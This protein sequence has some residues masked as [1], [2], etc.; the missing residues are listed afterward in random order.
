MTVKDRFASSICWHVQETFGPVDPA[1]VHT[2]VFDWLHRCFPEAERPR[3][4]ILLADADGTPAPPEPGVPARDWKLVRVEDDALFGARL[5]NWFGSLTDRDSDEILLVVAANCLGVNYSHK[6]GDEATIYPITR[7]LWLELSG[8][9]RDQA[10]PVL[11]AASTVGSAGLLRAAGDLVLTHP[12]PAIASIRRLGHRSSTGRL[13]AEPVAVDADESGPPVGWVIFARVAAPSTSRS[14]NLPSILFFT[15]LLAA[16]DLPEGTQHSILTDLRGYSPRLAGRRGNAIAPVSFT[17]AADADP[18]EV[19]EQLTA[20]VRSGESLVRAAMGIVIAGVIAR[21]GRLRRRPAAEG[22]QDAPDPQ[23]MT[24]SFSHV[25]LPAG[26]DVR[27]E[28]GHMPRLMGMIAP[29][30][31]RLTINNREAGGMTDLTFG[32]I[33][34]ALN[35]EDIRRA[36]EQVDRMIGTRILAFDAFGYDPTRPGKVIVPDR[37]RHDGREAKTAAPFPAN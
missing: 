9:D 21:R 6:F 36:L 27:D 19:A 23:R 4:R 20:R 30:D 24:T 15:H 17:M 2:V 1:R 12:R 25:R 8:L 22:E 26:Q 14:G 5:F 10:P 3:V 37:D 29:S 13:L 32:Y 28:T 11:P 33:G 34:S 31:N 7:Q 16:L 18:A 35:P